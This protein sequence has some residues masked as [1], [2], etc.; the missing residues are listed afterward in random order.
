MKN[1]RTS[2][3]CREKIQI[4]LF[5]RS[6]KTKMWNKFSNYP[7]VLHGDL[8]SES[9]ARSDAFFFCHAKYEKPLL[10]QGFQF[11][12]YLTNTV[13]RWSNHSQRSVK[14][15]QKLELFIKNVDLLI[16][17]RRNSILSKFLQNFT[18]YLNSSLL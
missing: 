18:I 3:L 8:S 17:S 16:D 13:G 5:Q 14:I 1:L 9:L 12:I 10:Y 11:H 2:S 15:R 6:T 4:N 7:R